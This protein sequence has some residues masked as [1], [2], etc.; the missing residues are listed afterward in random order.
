MDCVA[1]RRALMSVLV[2]V[3][4][5]AI[6]G[7]PSNSGSS[8]G[9][10]T[11]SGGGSGSGSGGAPSGAYQCKMPDGTVFTLDFQ[12][13]GKMKMIMTESGQDDVTEGNWV[14]NGDA[15]T[16]QA[17]DGP[18]MNITRSGNDLVADMGGI[19]M[20]FVKK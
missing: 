17:P 12:S 6:T 16:V 9:E 15:L 13:G 10:K 11:A 3:V 5:V 20:T 19:K 8:G 1:I 14:L 7:C 2:A 18:P 4:C